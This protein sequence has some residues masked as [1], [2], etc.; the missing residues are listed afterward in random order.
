M[1]GIGII[2]KTE[3]SVCFVPCISPWVP[4]LFFRTIYYEGKAAESSTVFDTYTTTLSIR[5]YC[6]GK[7]ENSKYCIIVS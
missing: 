3:G 1:R 4:L 6:R 7:P 2:I 5:I